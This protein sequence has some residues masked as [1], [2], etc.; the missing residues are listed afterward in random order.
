VR[1]NRVDQHEKRERGQ[2]DNAKK[3]QFNKLTLR[4]GAVKRKDYGKHEEHSQASAQTENICQRE[5]RKRGRIPMS[6]VSAP[7]STQSTQSCSDSETSEP[8][9]RKCAPSIAAV[10]LKLQHE[11]H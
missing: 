9:A 10:A 5:I 2:S 7:L 1:E 11:P 3:K 8:V 4:F 6:H